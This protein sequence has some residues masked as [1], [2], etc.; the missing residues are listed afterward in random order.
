MRCNV[1]VAVASLFLTACSDLPAGS[2]APIAGT[3]IVLITPAAGAASG[4]AFSTQPVVQLRDAGELTVLSNSTVVSVAVSSGGTLIGTTTA[5]TVSGHASFQNLGLS[6]TAGNY[7]LTYSSPELN[8]VSQSVSLGAGGPAALKIV[9]PAAV[10]VSGRPFGTPPAVA[11]T[12]ASGNIRT[13][14]NSTEVVI[15]ASAG[16]TMTGASS[17]VVQNGVATFTGAGIAGAAGQSYVLR[18]AA[19]LATGPLLIGRDSQTVSVTAGGPVFVEIAGYASRKCA[20]TS[21]GTA[22]CWGSAPVG[23]GTNVA[24]TNPTLVSGGLT[25]ASLTAGLNHTCGLTTSGASHCWGTNENGQLGDGTRDERRA[26][27]AVATPV[28]FASISAAHNAACGLTAGGTA[29]C[30]A[31]RVA[32]TGTVWTPSPL[33]GGIIFSRLFDGVC[34]LATSGDTYCW[35]FTLVG[36]TNPTPAI[37]PGIA[38]PASFSTRGTHSCAVAQNGE[39]Y[40]WGTNF[41]GELGIGVREARGMPTRVSGGLLFRFVVTN[42]QGTCGVTRDDALYCWGRLGD[43]STGDLLAP[44]RVQTTLVFAKIAATVAAQFCGIA[45]AGG[46]SLF[47]WSSVLGPTAIVPP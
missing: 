43:V 45:T 23:D 5:T 41:W 18:F 9:V 30:W 21:A 39:A 36:P 6:G 47:C 1:V 22:Y 2:G 42:D 19:T 7:I 4:G 13:Q 16:A 11:V 17:A 25:F 38:N 3:H 27:V 33:A 8:A 12:D 40:C 32:G 44:T 46:G 15:S 28:P 34:G 20:L 14:D 37:V 35:A 10:A 24:R 29:Y 26:P 31:S